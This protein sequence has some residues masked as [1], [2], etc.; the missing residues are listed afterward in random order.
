MPG[1]LEAAAAV[2]ISAIVVAMVTGSLTSAVRVQTACMELGNEM[3]EARQLEHLVDRAVLAAGAGPGHPA[4]IASLS[5]DTITFA[6]DQNG[7]GRVD[8]SSSETT[9]LEV[10][11]IGNQGRVRVRLGRQTMTVLEADDATAT[12]SAVDRSGRRADAATATVIDLLIA[13]RN[14][15]SEDAPLR[16]L[17]FAVPSRTR[18]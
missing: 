15:G 11:Q 12:I 18:Q 3:F 7:D 13:A 5:N 2:G 10:R 8:T 16:R 14:A 4:A 9:A 1:L 17:L 6:S